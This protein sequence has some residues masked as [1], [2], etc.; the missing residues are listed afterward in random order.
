MSQDFPVDS[1]KWVEHT[2][3]FNK[4]FVENY[5]EHSGE[6]CFLEVDAQYLKILINFILIYHIYMKE[7]KLK[8]LKNLWPNCMLYKR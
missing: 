1:F 7:W 8:K 2:S 3:Q 6:R 4:N 5:N